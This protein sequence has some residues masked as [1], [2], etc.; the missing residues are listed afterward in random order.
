M[1]VL[2]KYKETNVLV[3]SQGR[4]SYIFDNFEKIYLSFS[5]GKDSTV[6][7]HLVMAEA[8][9][10][11]RKIGILLVDLEAQY[12]VT[13]EHA[14]KCVDLYRDNIDL[15][16]V[17]LPLSLRNAVSNFQP[18]WLAWDPAA[19]ASWVRPL[20]DYAIGDEK[21]FPFFQSGM[22]FEEFVPLFGE[23]YSE[24]KT[25]ACFV[26]IRTDESLNRFRTI[27][28]Q[29]KVRFGDKTYTTKVTDNVFNVYPIY[30]WAVG[31][32]WLYHAKNPAL[33][34]NQVYD[35]MHKAGL[36][37]SQM[38]I[39]QPYGDDQR[40]GLWL[41]HILE[42]QTW[43]KVVSRVN[44]VNSGALY[45]QE[46]GNM[47][48]YAKITKPDNHT[49]KSFCN[50]LLGSLPDNTRDHYISKF[51]VFIKWWK[52]RGYPEGL[53]EEAPGALESQKL[54]PSWRRL[55]KVL[56]R[57]DYWCKGLAFTQPKSA[58][59]GR[60]LEMKKSGTLLKAPRLTAEEKED[61]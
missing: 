17:S 43:Y 28:L 18:R 30:D 55:C 3:E 59:Y 39:C 54:A 19:K 33:P 24:G 41:Y 47:T 21:F 50:L 27:A 13:M 22:E 31:D 1:S 40:R 15:F 16:W 42:P 57:N 53:P 38:R 5:A 48:G 49:W 45:I 36:S 29:T 60:Y 32:L 61:D 6:M 4:I 52:V 44:G 8:I 25:C 46:A 7:L 2:K 26:G 56:L 51:K 11:K 58:A 34:Y 20:P 9:K 14:E 10:R 35:L 23:W 37:P 12:K